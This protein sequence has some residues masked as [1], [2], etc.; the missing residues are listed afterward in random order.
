MIGRCSPTLPRRRV[1]DTAA[2]QCNPWSE[3]SPQRHANSTIPADVRYARSS[4]RARMADPYNRS[5]RGD[6]HTPIAT[7]ISSPSR[8]PSTALAVPP[9]TKIAAMSSCMAVVS[10]TVHGRRCTMRLHHMNESA[11]ATTAARPSRGFDRPNELQAYGEETATR[12][13]A[14]YPAIGERR[15][16]RA[17]MKAP[18]PLQSPGERNTLAPWTCRRNT[19]DSARHGHHDRADARPGRSR[20]V[21]PLVRIRS[22]VLGGHDRSR[23]V[24]VPSLGRNSSVEGP[25]LSESEHGGRTCR[26]GQLHRGVLVLGRLGRRPFQMVVR[27]DARPR[28]RGSHEPQSHTRVDIAVR[29]VQRGQ[30]SR[31]P[32]QAQIALDL[33][34]RLVA[35]GNDRA[36]DAALD[37]SAIVTTTLAPKVV[38]DRSGKRSSSRPRDSP[39][40]KSGVGVA[41]GCSRW[42]SCGRSAQ[43]CISLTGLDDAFKIRPWNRRPV[44]Q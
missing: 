21:Q 11:A 20:R 36:P 12:A 43:E 33:R 22:F 40:A 29:P 13:V 31:W 17:A 8:Q 23:C 32:V 24:R 18:T 35:R 37:R 42:S 9:H 10:P 26:H 30:P 16:A 14:D 34:T 2:K 38:A 27:R 15:D 19:Y 44:A 1:T 6:A 5:V 28:R 3:A 7:P 39:R 4:N 25:A 41:R